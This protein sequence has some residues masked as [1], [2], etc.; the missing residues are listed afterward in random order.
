MHSTLEKL[1][2]NR[3]SLKIEVPADELQKAIEVSYKTVAKQVNIPGFR[4][5]KAPKSVIQAYIG[6]EAVYKEALDKL[7]P[8]AY[9]DAVKANDINPVDYPDVNVEQFQEGQ[10]LVFT[11]TVQCV[12]DVTLGEY[13]GLSIEPKTFTVT[14]DDVAQE[15]DNMRKRMG[16]VEDTDRTVVEN[17]DLVTMDF[18]GKIEDEPFEG[19][20]A[21]D[22][23][24]EIG[25][26]TLI[27]GFEDQLIGAEVGKP[28]VV[29][30]TFPEDYPNKELAGTEATFDVTIQSI[31]TRVLPEL[32]DELA[33]KLGNFDTVEQL[34]EDMLRRMSEIGEKKAISEFDDEVLNKIADNA[35]VEIP[36]VM[37]E[38]RI[39]NLLSDFEKQLSY[40]K[41]TLKEYYEVTG[42][43][44][45]DLRESLR[46]RATRE[47]KMDLVLDTITAA[48]GVQSTPED[49]DEKLVDMATKYNV[50]IE[51][52][53]E[54]F[55]EG[56]ALDNLQERIKREK[57]VKLLLDGY[58]KLVKAD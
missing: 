11:A 12:P 42:S 23:N 24:L 1:E 5:G 43:E 6:K 26:G 25:S 39:D 29:K 49:V 16:T 4:K 48:E 45:K 10:P 51:K 8:L 30:V 22:F 17:G 50:P 33:K 27:P 36:A 55:N 14:E 32:D 18:V 9:G 15:I 21:E 20:T 44:E 28:A 40:Q 52:V 38:R 35:S 2:N 3:V 7:V 54:S 31:K 46:E 53:K 58:E 13:K 47:V 57:T 37:I 19:G 34:K 56:D 41:R